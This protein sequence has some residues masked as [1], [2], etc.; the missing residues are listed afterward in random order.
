MSTRDEQFGVGVFRELVSTE[1]IEAALRTVA[2]SARTLAW[3]LNG[4]SGSEQLSDAEIDLVNAFSVLE[5]YKHRPWD[6]LDKSEG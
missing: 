5:G 6:G 1:S 4:R 2:A 3:E